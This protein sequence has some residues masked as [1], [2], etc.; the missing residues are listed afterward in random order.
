MRKLYVAICKRWGI[1]GLTFSAWAWRRFRRTGDTFWRDR[2]DGLALL[3]WSD[4]NHCQACFQR[5]TRGEE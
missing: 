2:F 5:E 4:R 1:D 3:F